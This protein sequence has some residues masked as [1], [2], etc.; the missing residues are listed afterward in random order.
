[1]PNHTHEN[2]PPVEPFAGDL[3]ERIEEHRKWLAGEPGGRRLRIRGKRVDGKKFDGHSLARAQFQRSAFQNCTFDGCDLAETDFSGANLSM[4][5]LSRTRRLADHRLGAANL[6]YTTLPRRFTFTA[7]E[8]VRDLSRR[9]ETIFF[10][11]T[12][13]CATAFILGWL[14]SDEDLLRAASGI[15]LP[16]VA[17]TVP[18]RAFY[19]LTPCLLLVLYCFSLSTVLKL[20]TTLRDLPRYCRTTASCS[21]MSRRTRTTA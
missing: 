8:A 6:A 3:D 15:T 20:W 1:M 2:G 11:L 19:Y 17:V 16:V 7:L 14:T 9:V 13:A 18:I 5:D 21:V 4:A 10:T 12:A